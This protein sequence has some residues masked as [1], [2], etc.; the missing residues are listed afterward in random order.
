[1]NEGKHRNAAFDIF[2]AE[3]NGS[4]LWI[5]SAANEA[6]AKARIQEQ[7]MGS[8]GDYLLL[9]QKTG[10]KLVIRQGG[11]NGT[12]GRMGSP[13]EKKA[14]MNDTELKYP[15]WQTPLQELILEFD[16]TKLPEKVQKAEA[17]ILERLQ[18]LGQGK[19]GQNEIQAIND[20]LALLR[21]LKRDKLGFPD[22]K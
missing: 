2:R 17:V 16:R 4:I 19:D 9:N 18:Q 15:E 14:Q 5:G 3:N 13:S 12:P 8:P 1:M 22:W 7:G 20:A 21:V 6:E 10:N 11:V